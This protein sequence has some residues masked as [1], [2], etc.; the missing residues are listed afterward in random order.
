MPEHEPA[1]A[2]PLGLAVAAELFERGAALGDPWAIDAGV[3]VLGYAADT[4]PREEDVE[5]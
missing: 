1:S 4:R 2:D 5:E 3:P